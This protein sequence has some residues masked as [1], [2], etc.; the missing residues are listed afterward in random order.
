MQTRFSLKQA[1]VITIA[2]M[3]AL[4]LIV[5][6]FKVP[7]PN[8]ILIAGLIVCS[9]VFGFSGGIPAAVIMFFYTLYFFSDNNSFVHF[10]P[11]NAEK[12]IV[13][14]IG[15]VVDMVFVCILKRQ[16]NAAFYE[17]KELSEKLRIEN[18]MLQKASKTDAL[19]GIGNRL[20]LRRD[21]DGYVRTAVHVIMVDV[22]NFK[23]IND[24]N[25]HIQGD[26]V[27]I[28]TGR[29]LSALFGN[30]HCYRY[31][32]DEFMIVAPGLS[33]EEVKEKI[34][35]IMSSQPVISEGSDK[36]AI[37]F[38]IGC[39]KGTPGSNMELRAMLD[40]ADELMYKAK[41]SGKN[42]VVTDMD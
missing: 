39:C 30:E 9:T 15:I 14:L 1:L 33:D 38:S 42:K 16:E 21:F 6:F 10:S 40:K 36:H 4:I 23:A 26:S 24:K 2:I 28:D 34:G 25:G 12:V 17:I 31:G 35:L 32:G 29:L 19:T 7:N 18:D 37:G 5:Y 27:L 3:F 8:M 22:D 41:T 20:A 11:E 13:S